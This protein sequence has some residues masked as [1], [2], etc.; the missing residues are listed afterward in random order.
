VKYVEKENYINVL[1]NAVKYFEE[2]NRFYELQTCADELATFYSNERDFERANHFY[3]LA[4]GHHN[5]L[6]MFHSRR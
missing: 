5:N 2:K 6:I 4:L 3:R 1:N